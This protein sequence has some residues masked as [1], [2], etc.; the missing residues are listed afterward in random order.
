M[1][2]AN[3]APTLDDFINTF[4][5]FWLA[6]CLWGSVSGHFPPACAWCALLLPLAYLATLMGAGCDP[7]APLQ[8]LLGNV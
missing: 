3:D 8:F 2:I 5:D 7:A 6:L 4:Q 1:L